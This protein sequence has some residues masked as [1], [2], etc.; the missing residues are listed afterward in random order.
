M[1]TQAP[2][3]L[4]DGSSIP[5]MGFGTWPLTGDEAAVAVETALRTG[6]RLIDT[7]ARYDNEEDVGRGLHASGVPRSEVFVTT[8]LAG[9]DHGYD[10]TLR[11][12]DASARR[13]GLERVD[14]YLIHW[15]LPARNLY[16]D[17]WRAFLRLKD[18]GRVRSVGVSNFDPEHIRRLVDVTG[19]APVVNQVE[20]HPDFAQKPLRD[21]AASQ[22]I[23]VEAWSPLGRGGE[24]LKRDVITRLAK[25][26]GRSPA[27]IILRW[28][29]E[30]G[31]VA[32]PKSQN[33]Q[34]MK[35]NLEVFDFRLDADD[36]GALAA[37][38]RGHRQGGDPNVYVE[39]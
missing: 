6:Y 4:N 17:S 23:V 38:D 2:R 25:K 26:H 30:L 28:H 10:A 3:R 12:F 5:P 15:P 27:Q 37:L 32:I 33:P 7:A 14:L 8:K 13:L 39:L 22:G 36:L 34:R 29:V 1:S 9:A 19:V 31:N 21:D 11:A 35:E 16:V 18:E 24:L 20:L